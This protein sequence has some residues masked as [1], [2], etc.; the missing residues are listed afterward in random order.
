M[1]LT[2]IVAAVAL[3]A[4][5]TPAFAQSWQVYHG[6]DYVSA[7]V[8]S[9]PSQ[10]SVTCTAGDTDPVYSFSTAT[11]ASNRRVQPLEMVLGFEGQEFIWAAEAIS[12]EARFDM[13]GETMN[14]ADIIAVNDLISNGQKMTVSIPA[15]NISA[16]FSLSGSSNALGRVL[17]VCYGDEG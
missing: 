14:P 1:R 11:F 12:N 10:F 15:R 4:V 9:G 6:E 2:A 16:S 8:N 5:A 7:T 3:V 13:V 17:N